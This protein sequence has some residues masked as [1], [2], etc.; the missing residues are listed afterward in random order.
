MTDAEI[1]TIIADELGIQGISPHGYFGWAY[2][3]IDPLSSGSPPFGWGTERLRVDDYGRHEICIPDFPEDEAAIRTACVQLSEAER[4]RFCDLLYEI[5]NE[6]LPAASW[7]VK[8]FAWLTAPARWR[9]WAFLKVKNKW[10]QES[11]SSPSC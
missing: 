1:R 9:C 10:K 4:E 5:V 6:I 8:R 2:S 11:S 7:E 3:A